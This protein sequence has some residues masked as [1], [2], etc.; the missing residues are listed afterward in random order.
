MKFTTGGARRTHKASLALWGLAMLP[1]VVHAQG[2]GVASL[3]GGGG[4]SGS[5]LT[6]NG[7]A[8][9]GA[10]LVGSVTATCK[11]GTGTATS[12]LDGSYTVV[13]NNGVGPC[14]LA[15]TPTGGVTL[16]SITSGSGATQTANIT[17]MTNLLV[18]YLRNVPGM[19]AA[20]PAAWFALPSVKALLADT[21]ALTARIVTDFIPALQTLLP[22]LSVANAG[23][24]FTSF[25]ASPTGSATDADLE[26]L[27]TAGIVLATGL[28]SPAATSAL[29]AAASNDTPVVAPT[30]ATG[31]GS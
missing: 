16:Y 29:T 24:L 17:P 3:G 7:T 13:V 19:T 26:K 1:A 21:A 6:V 8:A 2:L 9:T 20:D 30:G 10:P 11:T 31:A 15:I 18:N 23:F 5:A 28:A 4:G 12:N 22:T 27:K 25:V 14:L